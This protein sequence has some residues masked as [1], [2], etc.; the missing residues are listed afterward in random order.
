MYVNV[1]KCET[2]C[3]H[4]VVYITFCD[5]DKDLAAFKVFIMAKL[6]GT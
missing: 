2:Q 3:S 5:A 1:I 4:I 6:R